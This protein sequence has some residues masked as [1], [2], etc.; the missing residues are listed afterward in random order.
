MNPSQNSAVVGAVGSAAS[1]HF[2]QIESSAAVRQTDIS[3]PAFRGREH[4]PL[5]EAIPCSVKRC[6]GFGADNIAG[7][8]HADKPVPRIRGG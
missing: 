2:A 3:G 1:T 8:R 6:S 5:S 7:I 4:T